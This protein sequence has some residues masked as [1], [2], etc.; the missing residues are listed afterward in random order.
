MRIKGDTACQEPNISMFPFTPPLGA[1][2]SSSMPGSQKVPNTCS[3]NEHRRSPLNKSR[4]LHAGLSLA[5]I[6]PP[7]MKTLEALKMMRV[8]SRYK[9]KTAVEVNK[10]DLNVYKA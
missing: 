4:P 7:P 8:G 2:E 6:I 3:I 5:C 9:K 1:P 10:S